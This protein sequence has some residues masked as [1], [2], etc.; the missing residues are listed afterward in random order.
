MAAIPTTTTTA[1]EHAEEPWIIPPD[2][3]HQAAA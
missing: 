1:D 3:D 2:I